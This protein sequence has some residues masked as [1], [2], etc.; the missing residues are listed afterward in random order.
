MQ[1]EKHWH[2]LHERE[3]WLH[4]CQTPNQI[5]YS[6]LQR[7]RRVKSSWPLARKCQRC[8]RE[9][10]LTHIE[11]VGV[12]VASFLSIEERI[13]WEFWKFWPPQIHET[14]SLNAEIMGRTFCAPASCGFWVCSGFPPAIPQLLEAVVTKLNGYILNWKMWIC[15][16]R[17]LWMGRC[18]GKVGRVSGEEREVS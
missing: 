15:E 17:S 7:H 3:L 4:R 5:V 13:A 12:V 2:S 10:C 18:G 8:I 14:P 1:Q 16:E 6:N 11:V 9:K